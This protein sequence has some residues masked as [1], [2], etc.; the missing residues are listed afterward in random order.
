MIERKQ[1]VDMAV[2]REQAALLGDERIGL[3]LSPLHYAARFLPT[4]IA[5]EQVPPVLPVWQA[6]AVELR[7]MGYSVWAG[8]LHA[9]QFGVPQTRKRAI[10]M[11][12][13]GGVE[14]APPVPTHSKYHN[15]TPDKL[16]PDVKKWVSMEE[17][18]G[19]DVDRPSPTVTGGRDWRRRTLR[20]GRPHRDQAG[21]QKKA[22]T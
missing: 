18:L 7:E 9:E 22:T 1:Y 17:A 2:L 6:M 8:M 15:R 11:A 10:L 20:A 16:D 5:F 19:W 13:R 4:Y 12:R 3:V 14:V 21:S